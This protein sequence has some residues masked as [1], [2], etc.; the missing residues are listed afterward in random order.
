[1]DIT[2][3]DV[4][5][6]IYFASNINGGRN[7]V[8]VTFNAFIGAQDVRLIEYGGP[9]FIENTTNPLDT[10]IG[11]TG[12]VSPAATGTM[13]TTYANDVLDVSGTIDS[14]FT[15]IIKNCGAGCSLFAEI[16]PASPFFDITADALVASAGAYQG[17]A[18]T[19]GGG[20][21]NWVFQMIALRVAGQATIVNPA[22][23]AASGRTRYQ[24]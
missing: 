15:S 22:P 24:P 2:N 9:P 19:A 3:P 12:N 17:Q 21:G 11:S 4:S 10:S 20:G 5:Q 14:G 6:A 16:P 7:T 8:T 1:M 13:T 23:A 18:D